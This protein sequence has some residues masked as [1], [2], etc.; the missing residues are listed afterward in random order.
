MQRKLN[1]LSSHAQIDL[2]EESVQLTA[3][4][5][6]TLNLFSFL[7][8][9]SDVSLPITLEQVTYHFESSELSIITRGYGSQ[10]IIPDLLQLQNSGLSLTVNLQDVNTLA[11]TFTGD[12]VVGGTT[13]SLQTV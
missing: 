8:G 9:G 13:I 3:D 1:A 4:P 7:S 5:T 6:A 11:I 2:N 12:W 10:T